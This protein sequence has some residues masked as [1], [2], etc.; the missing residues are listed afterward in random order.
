MR[1]LLATA[2]AYGWVRQNAGSVA[3]EIEFHSNIFKD[4]EPETTGRSSI[5]PGASEFF[6]VTHE[7]TG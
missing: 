3:F 7:K 6:M 5:Y 1:P 4:C 2:M